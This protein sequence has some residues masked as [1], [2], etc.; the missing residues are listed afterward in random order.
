MIC[1]Q[2]QDD[3]DECCLVFAALRK[4][5][6]PVEGPPDSHHAMMT[7]GIRINLCANEAYDFKSG[8]LCIE[9]ASWLSDDSLVHDVDET[10]SLLI[11]GKVFGWNSMLEYQHRLVIL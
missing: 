6:L 9:A 7:R 1:V 8:K 11:Y 10:P 5:V 3:L 4:P 2:G